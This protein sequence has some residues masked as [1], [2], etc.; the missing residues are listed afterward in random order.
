MNCICYRFA[1]P[2]TKLRQR[3]A[4]G[5]R[6]VNSLDELARS[7]DIAYEN[8]K[9]LSDRQ[10]ADAILEDQA[11]EVFKSKKTGLKEKA[12]SW[13][14][15]TAMKAKRK[16]GAGCRFKCAVNA[17]KKSIKNK[18]VGN[19]VL[20]LVKTCVVAAKKAILH[21]KKT[22]TP[23]IIPIPKKGGMLPLIPIFAGLSALG[24]LTG[25]IASVV[26]TVNDM[27]SNRNMPIHLGKGLYLAPYKN[28]TYQIRKGDGLYLTPYKSGGSIKKNKSKISTRKT[29]KN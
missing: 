19:D 5:E 10:K 7:H 9:L 22:K 8:S 13:L 29:T 4:R 23:R 11:W 12:A 1:G 16:L 17:A 21:K 6:G 18:K 2:G 20:K 15:T 26:K 3:L 24:S 27:R 28:N 25:G 14:V